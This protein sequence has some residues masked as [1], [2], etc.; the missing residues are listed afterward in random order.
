MS[1]RIS[2][3]KQIATYLEECVAL[4]G[5][6]GCMIV[7]RTGALMGEKIDQGVSALSFA[8]MSATILG[9]AEAAAGLMH[10][11]RPASVFVELDDGGI[12]ILGAGKAALIAVI[13]NKSADIQSLKRD[14][15]VITNKIGEK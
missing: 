10:F 4:D 5:V 12:I 7:S 6:S 8:A 13:I 1:D 14:L 3:K 15:A 2:I 11:S 9:S